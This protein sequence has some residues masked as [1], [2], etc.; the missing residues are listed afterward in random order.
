MRRFWRLWLPIVAILVLGIA[1]ACGDDEEE[2]GGATVSTSMDAAQVLNVYLGGEPDTLDPQRATDTVSITVLR[3]I[4]STL[5]TIDTGLNI[6]ADL[7]AEIPTVENGGISAD[8]LTYTFKLRDDLKWSDGTD[9]KAQAFVDGAK[10]LFDPG[11]GNYYVDFYRVLAA[12]GANVAVEEGLAAGDDMASVEATIA[13][14]LEVSAPDDQ[15]VVYKLNR[16]SPVFLLLTTMWPLYPVRQDLIDANGDQWTEAG[17]LIANGKFV[18]SGWDHDQSI[19]LTR[20][21]QYHGQKPMLQTINMGMESDSAI[22]FLAYTQGEY[23]IA[24]LGPEEL[25]Q[26]RGTD[27]ESEFQTYAS[28]V[29][30]GFYFNVED[31]MLTD[32][33]VRQAL[34]GAIDRVEY[35][36][37]VLEGAALPA[38]SW[39]PPG[40]PG[41]DPEAGLQYKDAVEASKQLLA[42][43]G[44]PGGDGFEITMMSSDT[45][46]GKRVSEWLKEQWETNLGI[47]VNINLLE[48]ATYFAERNAGNY[49]VVSGG[50]GADY[51]DP[52]N[53]L[54][55][56]KSGGLLNSGNFSDADFDALIQA[57]DEELD[58]AKR[59]DLYKQAQVRMMEQLP[60]APLNYR[61]KIVLVK[62]WVQGLSTSPMES[63]IP[64]DLFFESVMIVGRN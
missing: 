51:P 30:L 29:T 22:A 4:Y 45:S 10:R 41:H 1:A 56:F 40:M 58:N 46:G 52:Q 2:T 55:L 31:P 24:I 32:V 54:P 36:E 53:W 26:V 50:W 33:K 43:A 61:N 39:V 23:D 6:Q 19:T 38:Y 9:L 37:I 49:Q 62:P 20:S 25:V 16:R 44:Y 14:K 48:V 59:L 13:G 42:D 21:E 34:T 57:A 8:G 27:L 3:Q 47:K 11:V 5:L 63:N 18:L 64:G 60:F 17:N 12:G 15:T 35:A 7:A 28:L